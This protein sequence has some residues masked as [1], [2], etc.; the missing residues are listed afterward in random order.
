M[1]VLLIK[2]SSLGDVIH[3]LPAVT[4]ARRMRRNIRFDWV[5]EENFKEIPSWHPAVDRVIPVAFRR[6]RKNP[7]QAWRSGEL[8]KFHHILKERHYDLVIDAQGLLKSGIVSR[9]SRGLTLGLS[10]ST[11]R[12]P[13]ATLFY[14][15]VYTVP[16]QQHAVDRIRE[17]F[18]RAFNYSFDY[19]H[20]D[21]GLRSGTF[22]GQQLIQEK[23]LV[24]FHGTTWDSKLWPDQYWLQL[25]RIAGR[26]GYRVK[27]LWGNAVEEKR[28]KLL[29]KAG[30][31][32]EVIAPMGLTDISTLL[33]TC[34]GAVAVDTGLGH[35]AAALSVP[36]VSIYGASSYKLTGT[37]GNF[38]Q[39]LSPGLSCSP[40]M[41]KRCLNKELLRTG[42]YYGEEFDIKPP[43]FADIAPELV[44][45]S[46]L[47]Q[48]EKGQV[49][50]P[51][52]INAS[53]Y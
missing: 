13:I 37:W 50:H 8:K 36:T 33:T 48:M 30:G 17:L 38:Q 22:R 7:I 42:Q 26:E 11:V 3:A 32:V 31:H 40:C 53:V 45:K 41:S 19:D 12:E 14:N 52:Q 39:H 51:E 2:M 25:A 21:Y 15:M 46:L 6:W 24:F 20:C 23:T 47:H 9:L 27:V 16:W 29:A 34:S 49:T 44:W 5:V 1:H 18:S 43:C 28:A 35:L 4:D 10:N